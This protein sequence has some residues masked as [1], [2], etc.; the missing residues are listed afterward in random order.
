LAWLP[1]SLLILLILLSTPIRSR[2]AASP[3]PR[4]SAKNPGRERL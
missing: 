4:F 2:Q 3:L 1:S